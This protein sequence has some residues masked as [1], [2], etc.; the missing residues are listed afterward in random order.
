MKQANYH[1]LDGKI[2]VIT[3]GLGHLGRAI[4][5]ALSSQGVSLVILDK[6]VEDIAFLDELRH[7]NIFVDYFQVDFAIP[8][9]R[10][11]SFKQIRNKYERIDILVNNAAFVGTSN[12]AGWS[13]EFKEQ[14]VETWTEVIEV[15]LTTPF[16]LIQEIEGNL[17]ESEEPVILNIGSIYG[18]H[19]PDWALYRGTSMGNPA[20]YA[21][22][23]GGLIQLSRWLA[24][25][26]APEIR[27]NTVSPGGIYREQDTNF[28][29]RYKARSP[30]GRMATES[31]IVAA[32]IFL[33][34]NS[35]AYVTGQNI[36]VDGGWS[37]W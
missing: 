20:A 24:T 7:S 2:A 14:S 5:R 36:Q 19:G 1:D 21:A 9:E 26:L 13:V 6:L 8:E 29:A 28:V 23:K 32:V 4:C 18:T 33:V 11:N 34:S 16:H 17:R 35:S 15:N 25:T 3:G 22:S 27:V 10:I 37:A 12:L 31:E 30:L